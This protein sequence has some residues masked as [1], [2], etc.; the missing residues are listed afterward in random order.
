M[1]GYEIICY[2]S[3]IN[4]VKWHDKNTSSLTERK[5]QTL[6]TLDIET[7]LTSYQ[8]FTQIVLYI[9]VCILASLEVAFSLMKY[10]ILKPKCFTLI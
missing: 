3:Y 2:R 10:D 4:D 8:Q 5:I 1:H 7:G 9:L 6:S